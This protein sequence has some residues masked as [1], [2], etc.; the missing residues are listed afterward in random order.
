MSDAAPLALTSTTDLSAF[1]DRVVDAAPTDPLEAYKYFE[2]A[3]E[4]VDQFNQDPDFP[5][6]KALLEGWCLQNQGVYTLSTADFRTA[7]ELLQQASDQFAQGGAPNRAAVCKGLQLIAQANVELRQQNLGAGQKL[8]ADAQGL[9]AADP[10][11]K[12]QYAPLIDDIICGSLGLGAMQAA[13]MMNVSEARVMFEEAAIKAETIA[14]KYL[15]EGTPMHFYYLGMAKFQRAYCQFWLAQ[16]DFQS[17]SFQGLIE[18]GDVARTAREARTLLT[19]ASDLPIAAESYNL[20]GAIVGMLEVLPSAANLANALIRGLPAPNIDYTTIQAHL[21]AAQNAA[22]AGGKG[23][24]PIF[25][26]C[27]KI[28]Q[29][30]ENLRRFESDRPKPIARPADPDTPIHVFVIMPFADQSKLV[31]Q[32]LRTVLEDD[33]YWFKITLARDA[34]LAPNLLDNVKAHMYSADAFLADISGLNPNVMM[35]L[36]MV[37]SDPA[38]RPVFVLK[39]KAE[40]REKEADVPS[41]L[42]GRLY[43]EYELVSTHSLEEKASLLAKDLR[44]KLSSLAELTALGSRPHKRYTSAQYVQRKLQQKEI[45]LNADKIASLQKSFPSLEDLET[46]TA[47]QIAMKTGFNEELAGVLA[48]AFSSPAKNPTAAG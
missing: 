3:L 39:R 29:T 42:K 6:V 2:G 10:K 41:D 15:E 7:A 9:L 47:A 5:T 13:Q 19:Q 46:A 20:S 40:K 27:E 37:E 25:R 12:L 16:T 34:T 18:Q 28:A 32:A 21:K 26:L 30:V 14:H 36:G 8:M 45:S 11:L 1:V 33:P 4:Q 43:V 35:E 44:A 23:L 24:L 38:Q 31:E 22:A 48:R 17:F